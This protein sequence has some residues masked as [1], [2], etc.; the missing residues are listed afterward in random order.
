M[1][2][3]SAIILCFIPFLT[4]FAL[5]KILVDDISVIKELIA[6]LVGL[7]AL[8]PI[9]VIQQL[10]GELFIFKDQAFFSLLI[11]ALILYGMIEEGIKCATL[12]IFP[13]KNINAKQMFFYAM[14][15]GLFLG[16]FE[17]V[18]YLVNSIQKASSRGGEVLLYMI[19]IRTFTS[20]VIHTFCAGLSGLFVY[21]VYKKKPRWSAF[22]YTVVIHGLYDF[23]WIMPKPMNLFSFVAILLLIVECRICYVRVKESCM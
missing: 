23:F 11:R 14:L 20:I 4:A 10:C 15:A 3:Y 17:S 2:V 18:V 12:F 5:F 7:I 9:T 6:C 19:Y 13:K 21:S 8:I 1:N 16:C 22:V